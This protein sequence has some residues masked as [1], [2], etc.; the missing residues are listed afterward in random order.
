MSAIFKTSAWI[1][2]VVVD[3]FNRRNQQR[4]LPQLHNFPAMEIP[5]GPR[6]S[7][8]VSGWLAGPGTAGVWWGIKSPGETRYYFGNQLPFPAI[9]RTRVAIPHL[10][11]AVLTPP[12]IKISCCLL[13]TFIH[14]LCVK[15]SLYS[16]N[17]ALSRSAL[18]P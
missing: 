16:S 6:T 9:P 11:T 14:L 10:K 7:K 15:T 17:P 2:G 4:K 5:I 18:L 12:S 13:D 3:G 1:L 8:K